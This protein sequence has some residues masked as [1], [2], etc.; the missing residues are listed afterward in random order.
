MHDIFLTQSM[1]DLRLSTCESFVPGMIHR[2]ETF[3]C[4][5]VDC[6]SPDRFEL[7]YEGWR[8]KL[9]PKT[10]EFDLCE[11]GTM[12]Q[13]YVIERLV[14][15]FLRLFSGGIL[16]HAGAVQTPSGVI[17]LMASSGTG[18]STLTGGLLERE[19][20]HLFSDDILP[21]FELKTGGA[22][23]IPSSS[24]LAMRHA[25]FNEAP[26]VA[27]TTSNGYKQLLTVRETKCAAGASPIR[28]FVFLKQGQ[29]HAL[30]PV[31]KADVIPDFLRHQMAISNPVPEFSRSQFR[32][33]MTGI[34]QTPCYRMNVNFQGIKEIRQAADSLLEALL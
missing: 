32:Q 24:Q 21:I 1:H 27:S 16:L 18:K 8:A 17:V 5:E 20:C 11:T 29:A 25:L 4:L 31:E 34:Q 33:L 26:F 7:R 19:A 28:A 23:C 6:E 15:P 13:I 2:D 9:F 22:I 10:G 12:P 14:Q 3:G 30:H